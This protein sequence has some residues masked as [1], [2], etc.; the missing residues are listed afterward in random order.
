MSD[1]MNIDDLFRDKLNA[2]QA[3]EFNEASWS[4][5]E[6]MLNS[7]GKTSGK[8]KAIWW[9]AASLTG[10]ILASVGYLSLNPASVESTSE[11]ANPSTELVEDANLSTNSSSGTED[12]SNSENQVADANS[13]SKGD[14]SDESITTSSTGNESSDAASS[15]ESPAQENANNTVSVNAPVENVTSASMVA[16]SEESAAFESEINAERVGYS[17]GNT[18]EI[19][20]N[21]IADRN[22]DS[23]I[24]GLTPLYVSSLPIPAESELIADNVEFIDPVTASKNYFGII[25]GGNISQAYS[26]NPNGGLSGNEFIGIY[27]KRAFNKHWNATANLNYQHRPGDGLS[28]TFVHDDYSF[29]HT[30]T[31]TT[32][33]ASDIHYLE[34]PV[35]L[36]YKV[37]ERHSLY[38]GL[39][40]AYLLD[41]KSEVEIET[42]SDFDHSMSNHEEWGHNE[43]LNRTDVALSLG[44]EFGITERLGLGARF[45]YGLLDVSDNN[46]YQSAFDDRNTQ[47]RIYLNYGLFQF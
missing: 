18:E 15:N 4:N 29:G 47:F 41:S 14:Y 36:N 27:Y 34:L 11:K 35:Y 12:L 22:E 5:M 24:F 16:V 45:N 28:R 3:V 21:E 6:A 44:Y 32:V 23:D 46:Y 10:L 8:R 38:S 20:S 37:A 31:T 25:I 30:R 17:T 1:K 2:P 19:N 7:Q 26:A 9:S 13:S 43:G 39:S 40:V 33:T 42:T